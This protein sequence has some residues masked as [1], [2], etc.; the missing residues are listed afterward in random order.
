MML[1]PSNNDANGKHATLSNWA[2][3]IYDVGQTGSVS[4]FDAVY[5]I[6]K[7]II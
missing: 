5:Y 2:N 4:L 7:S 6:I 3:R 1:C